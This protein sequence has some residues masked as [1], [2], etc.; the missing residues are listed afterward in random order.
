M[1]KSSFNFRTPS[2]LT[3]PTNN[4][5]PPTHSE[6]TRGKEKGVVGGGGGVAHSKSNTRRAM[7]LALEHVTLRNG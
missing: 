2:P 6:P 1:R 7:S 5:K 4:D 3:V